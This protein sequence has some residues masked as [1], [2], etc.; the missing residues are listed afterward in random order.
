[1]LDACVVMGW[2]IVARAIVVR[3]VF[4]LH[5]VLAIWHLTV[6]KGNT[7]HWGMTA[8]LTGLLLETAVTLY[9]KRGEEWKW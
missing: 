1:M 9:V 6:V 8:A 2:F 5:G 7:T 3:L 4:A